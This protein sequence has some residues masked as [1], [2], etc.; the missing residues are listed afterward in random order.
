MLCRTA[1]SFRVDVATSEGVSRGS[2]DDCPICSAHRALNVLALN[3]SPHEE[4]ARIRPA[5]NMLVSQRT[6]AYGKPRSRFASLNAKRAANGFT[7]RE[8]V[9][10]HGRGH[11]TYYNSMRMRYLPGDRSRFSADATMSR[12]TAGDIFRL[13]DA[14]RTA[15]TELCRVLV[16]VDVAHRWQIYVLSRHIFVKSYSI[17]AYH[18]SRPPMFG[19]LPIPFCGHHA[20]HVQ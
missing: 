18:D 8:N 10:R 11:A 13:L 16:A 7:S 6:V 14:V 20:G 12:D 4:T 17:Y 5:P 2:Q 19:H 1:I 3:V 15:A 9:S